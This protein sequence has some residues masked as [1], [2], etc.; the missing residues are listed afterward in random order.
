MNADQVFR[1]GEDE[2]PIVVDLQEIDVPQVE[3]MPREVGTPEKM[4][5]MPETPSPAKH[6]SSSIKSPLPVIEPPR[7]AS[8]ENPLAS[9]PDLSN[10]ALNLRREPEEEFFMLSVLALKM[11]HTEEF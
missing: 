3:I 11:T 1:T 5:P 10:D 4:S 9:Q 6:N 8:S 7:V 2:L